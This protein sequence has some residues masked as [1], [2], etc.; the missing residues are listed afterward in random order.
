MPTSE[1]GNGNHAS[2]GQPGAGDPMV[3]Q[4][5]KRQTEEDESVGEALLDEIDDSLGLTAK[6]AGCIWAL[7]RLPFR[8]IWKLIDAITDLF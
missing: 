6:A 2:F 4:K 1:N 8:I 5:R 3:Q 7:I